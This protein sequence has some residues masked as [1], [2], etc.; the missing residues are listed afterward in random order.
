MEAVQTLSDYEL[1]RGKPMPSRNHAAIQAVLSAALLRYED[2]FSVLS[3]LSLELNGRPFVPDLAIY[4]RLDMDL[5]H[6]EVKRT[7]PP[8]Q[9]IEILSPTQALN[10]LVGKAEDYFNEGVK[11]CWIVQ[12]I[13]HAVAVLEP[14][15]L[16]RVLT[17][18]EVTDPVTGITVTVEEVF[19]TFRRP[20]RS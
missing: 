12:P 7:E 18:G 6:D 9:V 17:T 3:E 10:E 19:R 5:L 11:S 2:D 16:P 13:Q 4:P 1:E 15:Q 20:G 14:G 8:L